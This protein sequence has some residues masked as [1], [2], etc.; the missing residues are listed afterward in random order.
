MGGITLLEGRGIW[1]DSLVEL[2]FED[3]DEEEDVDE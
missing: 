3:E 2:L 1:F